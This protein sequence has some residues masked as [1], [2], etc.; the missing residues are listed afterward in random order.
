VRNRNRSAQEIADRIYRR[1]LAYC[2]RQVE[3]DIALL[4]LKLLT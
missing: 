2:G 1:A 4:V 3:D